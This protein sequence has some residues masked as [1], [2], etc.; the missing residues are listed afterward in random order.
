VK[1]RGSGKRKTVHHLIDEVLQSDGLV[2]AMLIFG[3]RNDDDKMMLTGQVIREDFT[4][5]LAK[6][7]VFAETGRPGTEEEVAFI[8]AA[9]QTAVSLGGSR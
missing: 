1:K 8:V 2:P 9:V 7:A 4:R 3:D 6:A 5:L